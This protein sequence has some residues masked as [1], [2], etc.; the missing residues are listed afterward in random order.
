MQ[1]WNKLGTEWDGVCSKEFPSC[2]GMCQGAPCQVW[3]HRVRL[4]F[5]MHVLWE[6]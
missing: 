5:P 2:S 4:C 3:S 1:S 6:L